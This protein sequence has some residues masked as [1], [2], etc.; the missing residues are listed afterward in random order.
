MEADCKSVGVRLRRFESCTCHPYQTC[1]APVA[2][3]TAVT[4]WDK[5]KGSLTS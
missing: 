4:V 3:A 1:A 5:L 2:V